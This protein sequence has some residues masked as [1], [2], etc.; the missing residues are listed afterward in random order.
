VAEVAADM[1]YSHH[2]ILVVDDEPEILDSLRRTLRDE[3]YRILTTTSAA[4]ALRRIEQGGIDLLLADLDMPEMNGLELVS[5]VR[6]MHPDV[7]RM[8]LTGHAS[9]DSAMQAINDGEVHRYLTKPW[10]KGELR[11]TIRQALDRLDELRRA[12]DAS[13]RAL[14]REQLLA[15]L[16]REHP[17]ITSVA[18]EGDAYVLDVKRLEQVATEIGD[19]GGYGLYDAVMGG[20]KDG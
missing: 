1:S 19:A 20:R 6:A 10:S 4:D 8:L 15:E 2:T 9:L 3:T 11:E 7:V 5:R 12:A 13:R 14:V 18:F 16:E 17:G